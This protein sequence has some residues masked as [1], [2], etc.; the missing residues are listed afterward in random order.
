MSKPNKM[1]SPTA[2][3]PFD[4]GQKSL[5]VVIETPEA[6]SSTTRTLGAIA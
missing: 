3:D 1:A 5:R 6:V 2:I 4:T